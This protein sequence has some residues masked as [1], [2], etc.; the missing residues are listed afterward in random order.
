MC[1]PSSAG[2]SASHRPEAPGHSVPHGA[3]SYRLLQR[4][5]CSSGVVWRV[6]CSSEPCTR[7]CNS[8]PARGRAK[9]NPDHV[10]SVLLF[11]KA[12]LQWQTI[13]DLP[14]V[15]TPPPLPT[16][17]V[18]GPVYLSPSCFYCSRILNAYL[19]LCLA[20]KRLL[21]REPLK[22]G[23]VSSRC[24]L[25]SVCESVAMRFDC[26]SDWISVC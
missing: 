4:T 14:R 15:P 10:P 1:R 12:H 7:L 23:V 13:K 8:C 20:S 26:L 17:F 9:R 19:D 16:C 25:L 6:F 2:K 3:F 18:H 24:V 5:S 11:V 22:C 21:C